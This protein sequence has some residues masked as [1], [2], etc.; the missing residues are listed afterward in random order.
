MDEDPLIEKRRY[1]HI[2]D[3][4]ITFNKIPS[5][6]DIPIFDSDVWVA[7]KINKSLDIRP[8][9]VILKN[10]STHQFYR[11]NNYHLFFNKSAK[12]RLPVYNHNLK[13][14]EHVSLRIL[15]GD[16]RLKVKPRYGSSWVFLSGGV[17]Y[18]EK[19][20]N[21]VKRELYEELGIKCD[22]EFVLMKTKII[23]IRIP[24]L[25]KPIKTMMYYYSITLDSL[26]EIK[27]DKTELSQVKLGN[28]ILCN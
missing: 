15:V 14:H 25:N 4:V 1:G 27:L 23:H 2:Y 6:F 16:Q 21:A 28:T 20:E 13:L 5:K 17:R 8:F 22:A 7:I 18:M 26:P 9:R 12:M 3:Y 11:D 24:I 19:P 10:Y